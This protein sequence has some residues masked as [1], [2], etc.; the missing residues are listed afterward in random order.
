MHNFISTLA[1]ILPA[2]AAAAPLDQHQHQQLGAR[3]DNPGCQA[4]GFGGDFAWTVKDFDYHASYIFTTPAHQNS[5]GYVSFNLS[6]PALA[7]EAQCS[8]ASSQLSDFFYG[9]FPY[10]CTVPDADAGGST[11]TETTF[12]FS[13]PSGVLDVNQTWVCSDADPQ[14]PTTFHAYGTANL[15]LS[16]TVET[17]NN[18]DWQIG[19]IY[20]SR[21]VTCD[22]VTVPVKP[23]QITAVA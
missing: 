17:V 5:W 6:N 18:P 13:R 20:S 10:T 4:A 16:C 8:A 15:T 3:D 9:N 7:Y 21:T 23:Y 2:L 22:L 1:A 19:E 14:Y 11:T 12:D